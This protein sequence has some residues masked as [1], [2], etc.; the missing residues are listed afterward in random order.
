[1]TS[2]ER[3]LKAVNHQEPDRVPIDLGGTAMTGI[4]AQ[5]LHPLRKELGLEERQ[6]KVIEVFQMLGEVEADVVDALGVD[7]LP[8]EP[9]VQ[10]F[11]LPRERWKPW[12]LF[13]GTPVLA[14]GDFDVEINER[15]DWLL[16]S[17]G[18]PDAP[19]VA[20]MP[21]DGYY[22]DDPG[23][24]DMH[25]GFTPPPIEELRKAE[26]PLPDEEIAFMAECARQL[27]RTTDKALILDVWRHAGLGRVGSIPDFLIL[28]ATDQDYVKRLF[29]FHTELTLIN[30]ERLWKAIGDDADMIFIDGKDYGAQ[31][32]EM[33]SP[34][35]FEKLFLPWYKIIYDWV[36]EHTTWKTWQ[37]SCGSIPNIIPMLVESGLDVLN[38]VQTSAAG[39]EPADLKQKFGDRLTFWGGGVDTQHTL[40]FGTP[41]EVAAE[42]EERIRIFAPGGGFVFNPVHNIQA[43]TPPR[44]IITAYET[45]RNAGVY[46]P[47]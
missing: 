13:D 1:M 18:R 35:W 47:S 7:V 15:G 8:V 19:V 10:L 40:P 42:V 27:R 26:P 45:A 44:N 46:S 11:E 12:T 43:N 9:L 36:H 20:R 25:P 33:F 22:F 2:R 30:Y 39:M 31:R 21:R 16:H 28:L 38:P 23:L 37:H 29:E 24:I 6:V 14:P 41:E 34:K 3:V 32:N 17:G 5:A 4:M